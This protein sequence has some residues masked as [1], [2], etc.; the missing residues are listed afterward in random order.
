M[1]IG[2][3]LDDLTAQLERYVFFHQ[4]EAVPTIVLWIVFAWCHDVASYSPI[5]VAQAPTIGSAKTHVCKVIALLTPR[6]K[7]IVEPT[8]TTF[9]RYVDEYRPTLI[10]DD[11]DRLLPRRPD[12][13]HI[14]NS[15]Y[16]ARNAVMQRWNSRT[17][18]MDE[19]NIFCPKVLNG[20]DLLAH[21]E[22][23]TRSRCITINML[24]KLPNE[25]VVDIRDADND[26]A[27][28]TLRSKLLRCSSDNLATLKKARPAMPTGYTNRLEDNFTLL[29]AIADLAGGD[30]PKK[31][32]AAALKLTPAEA[33]SLGERLLAA[34]RDLFIKHGNKLPSERI[35]KLLETSKD[36]E[37]ADYRGQGHTITQHQ[38]AALLKPFG[39]RP[40]HLSYRTQKGALSQVVR[41]YDAS[42][43]ETA[44]K[45]YLPSAGR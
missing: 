27:F 6:S 43:F 29:F 41:G 40:K 42:Q 33:A 16:S 12:L 4:K 22:P 35:P 14:I 8:G 2:A 38:I 10:V 18:R 23:A 3:L 26:E 21:L 11:A 30:W 31:A 15:A 24:R 32:R 25:R 20:I 44:F 34:F 17:R 36:P 19:F 5:L 9:Y 39:I 37:W 28:P 45:H 13:T 7:L 1:E